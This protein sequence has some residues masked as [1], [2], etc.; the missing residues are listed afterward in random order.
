MNKNLAEVIKETRINK[1]LTQRELADLIK[2]SKSYIN[3]IEHGQTKKPSLEVL[4]RL[5]IFLNLDLIDI[6]ELANY[7]IDEIYNWQEIKDSVFFHKINNMDN[8][9]AKQ[10]KD[11]DNNIDMIKVMK[12]YKDAKISDIDTLTLFIEWMKI[13]DIETSVLL[14]FITKKKN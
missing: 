14:D 8:E 7:D 13:E 5:S 1:K 2:V 3:K 9:I 10:Y 12:D 6:V 4:N 11:K